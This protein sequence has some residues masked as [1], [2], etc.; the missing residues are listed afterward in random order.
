MTG[1]L[2]ERT[3]K[4]GK[5]YHYIVLNTKP[6]KTWIATGLEAKG[7][8]RQAQELLAKAIAEYEKMESLEIIP[9]DITMNQYLAEWVESTD[10]RETTRKNY[11]SYLN[12]HILPIKYKITRCKT[13][14]SSKLLHIL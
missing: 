7:N 4:S 10:V 1:S 12:H 9:T 3:M 5:I 13:L 2:Q 6:N 14:H 8:K 11:R